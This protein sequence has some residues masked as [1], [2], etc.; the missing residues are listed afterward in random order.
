MSNVTCEKRQQVERHRATM[1]HVSA[2]SAIEDQNKKVTLT[3]QLLPVVPKDFMAELVKTFLAADIPLHKLHVIQLFEN[4]GEEMPSETVCRDYVKILANNKQDRLKYLLKHK[5]IFIVI[6]ESEVDKTKFINIIVEDI[7]VPEKTYLIECCVTETV[8][9]SIICMK[10][11]DILRKLDIARENFLLLLSDATSYMT[12]CTATLKVLYP[13]LFHVTCLAH[14]LRNCEE[15]VRSAFADVDNL[16]A[17]VKAAT[18]KNKSGQ[19][20]FKH[21]DSPP[22]PVVTR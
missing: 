20:Q 12:A 18:I 19:A 1:K 4:L 3:Q 7:D 10:T 21:I 5:C 13:R 9:Q 11:D 2:R 16:V 17:R 6:D 8:N 15:K 22:E 14:M